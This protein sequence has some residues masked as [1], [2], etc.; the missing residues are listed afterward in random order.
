VKYTWDPRVAFELASVPK[1]VGSQLK[2][3]GVWHLRVLLWLCCVG[4]GTFDAAACAAAC[5]TTPE[6]CEEAVA[7]WAQ[8][9][10]LTVEGNSTPAPASPMPVGR[11]EPI[12][13]PVPDP[14]PPEQSA[15]MLSVPTVPV[16]TGRPDRREVLQTRATDEAFAAL[17]DMTAQKLGKV[18]SPADM[19]VYLYIYRDLKL[20]P[21][22]IL[23]IVGYAVKNGKT[24]L[25]YIEKTAINWAES[26]IVTMA[27]A[28]KHL[29]HLEHCRTAWEAVC[30]I[31]RLEIARPTMAQKEAACRWIYEWKLPPEV[32]EEAMKYT[33]AKLGKPQIPYTDRLLERLHADGVTTVAAARAALEPK[34]NKPAKKPAGRMKT[35]TGRAPSFDLG[36]YEE[37]ALRHRPQ[38][39]EEE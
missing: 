11:P 29:C 24:R 3:A 38:F 2:M 30:K 18:L 36:N 23:M 15:A 35:A 1:A 39:S 32:I 8:Q 33:E 28:D 19:S 4:Q 12:V 5:G 34:A 14:K 26:G 9:G 25:S 20:P 16:A 27:A 37:M 21:E 13:E 10:V 6:L 22:V 17:L 31:G 7:F